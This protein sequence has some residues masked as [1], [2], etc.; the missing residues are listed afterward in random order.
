MQRN[1]DDIVQ[2]ERKKSIRNIP[3]PESR[4]KHDRTSRA[5]IRLS[6][7]SVNK[8]TTKEVAFEPEIEAQTFYSLKNKFPKRN[9]SRKKIILA[10]LFGVILVI[11]SLLSYFDGATFAYTPKKTEISFENELFRADKSGEKGLV[12]SLVKLSAEKSLDINAKGE[13]EISRKASGRIIIY[14]NFS[15]SPQ[16]LIEETR[17]ETPQG[18]IFKIASAVTV[19]GKKADQPGAI[20]AL[21]Y[22]EKPGA[23]YN[24]DL[25]DFSLPGLKGTA[26]FDK[27]Y[28]RSKTPMEGGFIGKESVVVQEDVK[29]AVGLLKQK[30]DE[31]LTAKAVSEVPDGFILLRNLSIINHEELPRTK[32][33]KEGMV[34]VNLKGNL[35]GVMFKIDNLSKALSEKKTKLTEND[36]VRF[37]SFDNIKV[38][39][40]NNISSDLIDE[41]KI[42]LRVS[43]KS[44]L[45]W[46][47]DEIKLRDELVGKSK[48]EIS[49]I[50]KQ[51]PTISSANLTL[52]PF[53]KRTFPNQASKIT[54]KKINT[55]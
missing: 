5:N 2:P 17:F 11:F 42:E 41:D 44:T 13:E 33:S 16:R 26:R 52:R 15:E 18:K 20:E 31:E 40:E 43:G 19:P 4:R 35:T 14:N 34:S 46:V 22:A 21:V 36:R 9:A 8:K 28:A 49:N 30:L 32:S 50:L 1:L 10:I 7:D 48:R 12:Y 51:Y 53:W 38:S 23:D 3:I 54:I 37:D 25:T 29:D 45:L 6:L 47:T 24:I 39:Y 55:E 27:V